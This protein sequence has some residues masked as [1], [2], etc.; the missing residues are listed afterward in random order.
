MKNI[1]V[2]IQEMKLFVYSI[3]PY[4]ELL[5]NK[6]LSVGEFYSPHYEY[7]VDESIFPESKLL[8]EVMVNDVCDIYGREM[9]DVI[10]ERLNHH[11][12][13]ETA[14]HYSFPKSYDNFYGADY[15][16][17]LTWNAYL[18][19]VAIAKMYRQTTHFSIYVTD[20]PFSSANSPSV[21][22]IN[23]NISTRIHR[24]SECSRC[25]E[26]YDLEDV[27]IEEYLNK[28]KNIAKQVMLTELETDSE[29]DIGNK[30]VSRLKNKNIPFEL[31]LKALEG[32]SDCRDI[33]EQYR[34]IAKEIDTI[35][36]LFDREQKNFFRK[37]IKVHKKL[38]DNLI[39][40]EKLGVE[41][42]TL[43]NQTVIKF[44]IQQLRDKSSWWYHIFNDE[45]LSTKFVMDLANVRSGWSKFD[46]GNKQLLYSPFNKLTHYS[47]KT[48]VDA[49]EFIA[50][51]HKPEILADALENS[52]LTPSCV[53]LIAIY[54]NAGFLPVGG[55]LQSMFAKDFQ[56]KFC[57]FLCDINEIQKAEMISKI[58]VELALHTT[59]FDCKNNMGLYMYSELKDMY[60]QM[61]NIIKNLPDERLIYAHMAAL[62]TLFNFYSNYV[63]GR[64][65]PDFRRCIVNQKKEEFLRDIK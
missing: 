29:I 55:P 53:M 17:N 41:Q 14:T 64:K 59:T 61:P 5:N 52:K 54:L 37:T 23:S 12:M 63:V 8:K 33:L 60:E 27:Q 19:S 28:L 32:E 15:D 9:A 30:M 24:S 2:L 21:I 3:N 45:H 1:S 50:K 31:A 57:M 13:A 18:V 47:N 38:F 44:F 35:N 7:K 34:E 20:I 49:F 11:F 39:N 51:D 26:W 6:K 56:D 22:E 42:V 40:A 58:H 62:P 43:S 4:V 16:N 65:H 46:E 36:S 10:R 48:V 25:V